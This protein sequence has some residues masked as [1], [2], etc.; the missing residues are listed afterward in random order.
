MSVLED[1]LAGIRGAI[2]RRLPTGATGGLA[3]SEILRRARTSR[4]TVGLTLSLAQ[5]WTLVCL[6][7]VFAVLSFWLIRPHDF[8]WHVRAGQ[9]IVENGA[10]P[11][12]DLFSF[13]QAGEPWA[14]QSWLM[15]AALYLLYRAGGLALV[16]FCHAVAVT[17]A[18]ALV[19][20]LCQRASGGDLRL[21]ALVMLASAAA[22]FASWN[23]R[24]QTISLPL[25]GLVLYVLD[26]DARAE[27]SKGSWVLWLLP[28]LFA[29][30]ANA[31]G[32]FVVGLALAALHLLTGL[33]EWRWHQRGFPT[34]R[35]LVVAS[36]FAACLLTPLGLGMVEYVLGF[37]RHPVTQSLN[38]EFTPPTLRTLDGQLLFAYVTLLIGSMCLARRRPNLGESLVLACFGVLAF[39]SR[40]NV[41]WFAMASAP[42]IA[43]SLGVWL[44]ERQRGQGSGEESRLQGKRAVS[45]YP[46]D[47]GLLLNRVLT[48]LMS[49]LIV[50]SLPWL[51]PHLPLP[52]WRRVYTS[53]ETPV[54]A[55]EVLRE[56]PRV[57][58]VFHD[59][60]YGSYM[61]WASPDVP[62]FI[63]TRVELY[64]THQWDDY[65]ALSQG[66]YDWEQ[67][68]ESYG[69]DT[70]LLDRELQQPLVGAAQS[71]HKWQQLYADERSV[72]LQRTGDVW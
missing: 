65:I 45:R 40:R 8:W 51:R 15:E 28:P 43:V 66:R 67:I 10:V 42:T 52:A 62:V 48:A 71:D 49:L 63:D 24:P 54:R 6:G 46:T 41:V 53:P 25:F 58:R 5:V 36:S 11:R 60:G 34:R 21:A 14:F 38:M 23:V 13:T 22:G 2:R 31:H 61:I 19:L 18:Y 17:G 47:G 4:R 7:G 29:L 32:G 56:Q 55:V 57:S 3:D 35:L 39:V 44:E 26:S 64:P 27:G 50:L 69:V 1:R 33:V 37:F 20:R 16:I 9:W 12:V 59:A 70:L 30:W 72:L 68:L